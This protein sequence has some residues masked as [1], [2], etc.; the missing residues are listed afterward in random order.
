MQ[1]LEFMA[2]MFTIDSQQGD[3]EP[4][5]HFRFISMVTLN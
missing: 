2:S 1:H 4:E 5:L 3:Y